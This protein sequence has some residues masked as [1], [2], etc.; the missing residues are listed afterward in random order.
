MAKIIHCPTGLTEAKLGPTTMAPSEREP[1]SEFDEP[2]AS[3]HSLRIHLEVIQQ[4]TLSAPHQKVL[5]V[6]F[7][8]LIV[9][10]QGFRVLFEVQQRKTLKQPEGDKLGMNVNASIKSGESCSMLTE[11]LQF[12]DSRDAVDSVDRC[13]GKFN[14]DTNYCFRIAAR[15]GCI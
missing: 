7:D 3:G 13:F 2:V 1:G 4:S 9:G 10:G 6:K 14:Q 8:R 15:S 12:T 11:G 5:G